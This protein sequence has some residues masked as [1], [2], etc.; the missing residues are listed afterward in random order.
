[1]NKVYH[2][3]IFGLGKARPTLESLNFLSTSDKKKS[4]IRVESI[5]EADI[6]FVTGFL[7]PYLRQSL[8]DCLKMVD[9]TSKE[10]I[11]I[12]GTV[13]N[14]GALS[15]SM[16]KLDNIWEKYPPS[17]F[18]PGEPPCEIVILEA[19]ESLLNNNNDDDDLLEQENEF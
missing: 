4:F 11:L 6:V 13:L 18:I 15:F 9:L 17:L 7:Y 2:Y 14:G 5:E 12:G 3:H 19:L 1:M 8:D 16:K 10:I